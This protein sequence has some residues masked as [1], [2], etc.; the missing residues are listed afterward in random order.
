MFSKHVLAFALIPT[1]ACSRPQGAP[2]M[3]QNLAPQR[4]AAAAS[5]I[6]DLAPPLPATE[7][8]PI[9]TDGRQP[10]TPALSDLAMARKLI[11]NGTLVIEVESAGRSASRVEALA[12]A[13]GGYLSG[14]QGGRD[15]SGRQSSTITV[16]VPSEA[17]GTTMQAIRE[18]GVVEADEVS[19][20]DVG[21]EYA[22]LEARLRTKQAVA[23]RMREILSTKT[24]SLDDLFRAE[25]ELAS[26]LEQVE[27]LE[28]QRR[29]YDNQVALSTI[30]AS[31]HEHSAGAIAAAPPP[32]SR[33]FDPAR[34]AFAE[35]RESL[36]VV[37]GGVVY[38]S[39]V[40]GPWM[41]IALLA[42][43]V[44]LRRRRLHA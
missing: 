32:P 17:F 3:L 28:G 40:A 35:A 43:M 33:F 29:F 27:Q 38:V 16:R 4:D 39:V 13:H 44:L 14:L 22:D 9:T 37:V 15:G 36:A 34:R 24:A 10:I 18:L 21:R 20:Q 26:V 25:R 8:A 7:P 1:L 11:R 6:A 31:L 5:R 23:E 2:M 41:L 30:T 42:G 19:T 12:A